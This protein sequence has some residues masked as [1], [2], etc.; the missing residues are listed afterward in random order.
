MTLAPVPGPADRPMR[1]VIRQH[2]SPSR[3]VPIGCTFEHPPAD[4]RLDRTVDWIGAGME[5]ATAATS[6]RN[7][8]Q[9]ARTP[10]P[11]QREPSPSSFGKPSPP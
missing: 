5:L 9:K 1:R 3:L 11:A 7:R 6:K 4:P 8:T 10:P 2:G